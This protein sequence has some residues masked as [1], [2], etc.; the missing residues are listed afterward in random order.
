[1]GG[2]RLFAAV[3]LIAAC[4]CVNS[5]VRVRKGVVFDERFKLSFASE[6]H[7]LLISYDPEEVARPL[8]TILDQIDELT[9]QLK[10]VENGMTIVKIRS[11]LGDI[12]RALSSSLET[13][14]DFVLSQG[15]RKKRA[16][17]W[18]GEL[19]GG[20][21]GL[22]TRSEL[23]QLEAALTKEEKN[24]HVMIN[25]VVSHTRVLDDKLKTLFM[26]V[27]KGQQALTILAKRINEF[28]SRIEQ[29]QRDVIY[30]ESA[31][32]LAFVASELTLHMEKVANQI[33]H[34]A[35]TGEITSDILPPREFLRIIK[36]IHE[37][38]PMFVPPVEQNLAEFYRMSTVTVNKS[39]GKFCFT[40]EIPVKNEDSDF[41][42]FEVKSL[43]TQTGTEEFATRVSVDLPYFAVNERDTWA[44]ALPNLDRCRIGRTH[45]LCEPVYAFFAPTA[46]VCLLDV[47]LEQPDFARS[48]KFE[49]RADFE[50]EIVNLGHRWVVS[51]RQESKYKV[52]CG[53][54][55]EVKVL[56]PGVTVLAHEDG[57]SVQ[58]DGYR[59]PGQRRMKG[60]RV[61]VKDTTVLNASVILP[62]MNVSHVLVH[63]NLTRL[64]TM[65]LDHLPFFEQMVDL[66]TSHNTLSVGFYL[67]SLCVFLVVLG[68]LV[69]C[70]RSMIC[71][72]TCLRCKR[73]EGD[74]AT[75]LT[76]PLPVRETLAGETQGPRTASQVG[77]AGEGR[78]NMSIEGGARVYS[79]ELPNVRVDVPSRARMEVAPT[80]LVSRNPGRRVR[81]NHVTP[82]L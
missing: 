72:P 57:C 78:V 43:W 6:V 8:V 40:V 16:A 19:V 28:D 60:E 18:I 38:V 50:R 34:V 33:Q 58:G 2:V 29:I 12:K 76:E 81:L 35:T 65:S 71:G 74:R 75:M 10:T 37:V 30:V 55:N 70:C 49:V 51:T 20:C 61:T 31:A 73:A 47:Y 17:N 46:R 56:S 54:E 32:Q 64:G 15:E 25:K 52:M 14:D 27:A 22:I 68:G 11:M 63:L 26:T 21:T 44:V 48:C 42:L 69:V 13:F 23:D 53:S 24:T 66:K 3:C 7:V 77:H 9:N 62:G 5:E 45:V 36:K 82:P 59:L 1:M 79:N 67:A 4:V 41:R 39:R 80:Q